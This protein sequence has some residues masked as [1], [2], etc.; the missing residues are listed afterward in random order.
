MKLP[1][2]HDAFRWIDTD[3][4]PALVCTPLEPYAAHLFT[5]RRW[6]LGSALPGDAQ[7]WDEV[8]HAMDVGR[9]TLVR[10]HQVHGATVVFRRVGEL[11][12]VNHLPDADIVVSNDPSLALAI[13]TADCVPVL[14]ADRRTGVVA[15]AHAGW[16]GLA[17][18][19]P[20]EAVQAL[21]HRFDSAPSDLVAALGPSISAERYEVG[22]DV[23][24]KFEDAGFAAVELERWFTDGSRPEH[25][26]FDGA[27]SAIDQLAAAGVPADQI[28]AAGLCTAAYP[29][30]LC[31]YRRDWK[32]AGRMAAVIR[33]RIG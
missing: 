32:D 30:W 29:D 22:A 18:R 20:S 16:R 7:A 11:R 24:Q 8:A 10:L 5:T 31:S 19:V 21:G 25:W 26:Q 17:A 23:R 4:G 14:I 3:Y 28:F 9:A 12:D 2:P 1:V 27:R 6:A 13:Q 33:A 15:A